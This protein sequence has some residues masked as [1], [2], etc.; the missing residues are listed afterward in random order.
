MVSDNRNLMVFNNVCL[1]VCMRLLV[2]K[3]TCVWMVFNNGMLFHVRRMVL[4]YDFMLDD[5]NRLNMA[6]LNHSVGSVF[7][8]VMLSDRC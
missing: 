3:M 1:V 4:F 6:F 7:I 2:D 8:M 5:M